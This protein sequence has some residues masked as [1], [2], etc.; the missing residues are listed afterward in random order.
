LILGDANEGSNEVLSKGLE[1]LVEEATKQKKIMN[2]V[3]LAV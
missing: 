2:R 3:R 1:K